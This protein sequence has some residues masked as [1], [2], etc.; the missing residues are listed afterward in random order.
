MA[1]KILIVHGYSDGS[2]SFT[3]LGEFL[4]AQGL[5]DSSK[6]FYIDYSSMD[7]EA[8]FRDFADKV[9]ADHET[10]LGQQRVDVACHSTGSLVVRAWLTL[11][12]ERTRRRGLPQETP[13][14]VDRL[15]CFAPANFGSD[16]ARMGQS[17]LGKFRTTFF[18]NHSRKSDFLESGKAVLQGLEPASPFQWELSE[19]DLH[20]P[21]SYFNPARPP[22]QRCYPFVFAAGEAYGGVE[23]KLVKQRAMP[24]TDGTVR[25]AGTSLNTRGCSLD[26]RHDRAVLTWWTH[27]KYDSVPFAVFAGVNHGSIVNPAHPDFM[28]PHGPGRLAVD[29]LRGVSDLDSFTAMAARFK[30]VSAD[31][32]ARLPEDR[33]GAYQQ[34]F[35][36]V[37]DDVNMIVDDFFI[38]FYVIRRD[39]RPHQDLTVFFEEHFAQKVTKHSTTGS[40]RVFLMGC[41]RM[42]E[43]HQR[44]LAEDAV[45][46]LEITGKSPLPDVIYEKS[47]RVA[48]DPKE[49]P[50]PGV[51]TLLFENTTTMVDV[52]LNRKQNDRLLVIKN[53]RLEPATAVPLAA[54]VA[55]PASGRAV[56]VDEAR[57]P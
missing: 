42:S 47:S 1:D 3:A 10:R 4:V 21:D 48:Y 7:D 14:P 49:V 5:Y 18:N 24:G 43:L 13:C 29:V 32:Q 53:A 54:A 31:N 34:F 35:F 12:A 25:I 50:Q 33:R 6:V 23:A 57:K 8:T 51:P 39:G 26:F 46:M 30:E 20:G 19:Y 28:A 40:H 55:L 22:H 9:D 37:R 2:T 17:F 44:L 52:V 56:L 16:L 15:L 27:Y 45:L 36:K 38:D 11:H 41:G